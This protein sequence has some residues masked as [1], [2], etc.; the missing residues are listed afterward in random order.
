MTINK[1]AVEAT[2]AAVTARREHM[3]ALALAEAQLR[4]LERQV[5][6]MQVAPHTEAHVLPAVATP[7]PAPAQATTEVAG[8]FYAG[9]GSRETP[10]DILALMYRLAR[11]MGNEGWTL[12]TG[13]AKG[14]DEAF[15]SG[16][17][18]SDQP[19][20]E[21]YLPWKTFRPDHTDPSCEPVI[22]CVPEYVVSTHPSDKA[23]ALAKLNWVSSSDPESS[24]RW[25]SMGDGFKALHGRNMEVILGSGLNAPVDLVICWTKNGMPMG[26]T[27]TAL[28]VA[29]DKEIEILNLRNQAAR[30]QAISYCEEMEA[31]TVTA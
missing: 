13:G 30:D 16:A 21:I 28:S 15:F 19:K 12:S 23:I 1:A 9:I 22:D 24:R 2:T 14:A 31:V 10:E 11:V 27:A 7:A 4:E 3:A 5:A 25:D 20:A 6:G 8:R 29:M 17:L 18:A 26:G